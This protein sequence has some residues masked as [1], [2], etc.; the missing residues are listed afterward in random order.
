M[1]DFR[2][3]RPFFSFWRSNVIVP[4]APIIPGDE[5]RGLRPQT[6]LDDSVHLAHA[7]LHTV[8]DVPDRRIRPFIL[9][10]GRMLAEL[11]RRVDPR[12]GR[13][14]SAGGIRSALSGRKLRPSRQSF[15]HSESLAARIAPG[16]SGGVQTGR[17]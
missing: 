17:P 1:A 14:L 8:G 3:V 6:A 4:A 11:A 9:R 7:P 15:D 16:K 5:D 13:K 10:D 2:P 12:N